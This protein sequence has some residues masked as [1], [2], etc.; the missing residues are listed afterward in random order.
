MANT[1]SSRMPALLE[2]VLVAEDDAGLREHLLRLVR[3]L[4][5]RECHGCESVAACVRL[6]RD[7]RPTLLILDLELTD[8]AATAALREGAKLDTWP[9]TL[10]VSGTASPRA[11]FELAML[12]AR[13]YLDKPASPAE[14]R[15]ALSELASPPPGLE[16]AVRSAVGAVPFH[17]MQARMRDT[18]LAEALARSQGN[19]SA[20]A[21]MLRV[22]RQVIQHLLRA[23]DERLDGA[24]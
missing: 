4:G 23:R 6:L 12:G 17:D 9:C 22:S 18:M 10:V 24:P 11:A 2:R 15:Q 20:A 13:G 3:D 5:A 8:G 14:L 21:R 19:R 7:V 16:A 1:V